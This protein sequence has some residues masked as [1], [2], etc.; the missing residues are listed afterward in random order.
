M[1][2]KAHRLLRAERLEDRW[3]LS[4]VPGDFDASGT[5]NFDDF[6]IFADNFGQADFTP[7]TDLDASGAVNFDDFFIFADNF[8]K[9]GTYVGG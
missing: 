6:F 9:T 1:N 2:R 3:M 8:G 7:A 4:G 5:V